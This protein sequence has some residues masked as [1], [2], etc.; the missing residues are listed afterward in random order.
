MVCPTHRSSTCPRKA[1][2]AASNLRHGAAAVSRRVDVSSSSSTPLTHVEEWSQ[3]LPVAL[4]V[5][6]APTNSLLACVICSLG[7][8]P[9][10]CVLQLRCVCS[11]MDQ[12]LYS[13]GLKWPSRC[14]SALPTAT[15]YE[16]KPPA[17]P[18]SCYPAAGRLQP[19]PF[20][21]CSPCCT[22][23][24]QVRQFFT[25]LTRSSQTQASVL[26]AA[27]GPGTTIVWIIVTACHAFAAAF[28]CATFEVVC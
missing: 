11:A 23:T 3:A 6:R 5:V 20:S 8:R 28:S 19:T 1:V 22:C 10:G 14:A 15:A 25:L 17:H 24:A 27:V 12:L 13:L 21:I 7:S 4:A 26:S 16:S 2:S 9:S 18:V